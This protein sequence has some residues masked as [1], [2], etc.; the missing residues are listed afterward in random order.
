M[1]SQAEKTYCQQSI[2]TV[3]V[4]LTFLSHSFVAFGILRGR[5]VLVGVTVSE[6][7]NFAHLWVIC[8]ICGESSFT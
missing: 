1:H 5:R 8:V 2:A 3:F 6:C 7:V 4:E